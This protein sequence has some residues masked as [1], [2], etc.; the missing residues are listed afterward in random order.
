[1]GQGQVAGSTTR[2]REDSTKFGPSSATPIQNT[3]SGFLV[4]IHV[5]EGASLRDNWLIACQ[6]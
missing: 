1:M 2:G 5:G 3:S 4:E 6:W